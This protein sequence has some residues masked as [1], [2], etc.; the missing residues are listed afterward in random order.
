MDIVVTVF[1]GHGVAAGATHKPFAKL[2]LLLAQLAE[3]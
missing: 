3:R 1:E 2:E